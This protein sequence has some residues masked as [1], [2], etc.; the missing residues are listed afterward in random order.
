[1]AAE[2]T[3]TVVTG[4]GL[5]TEMIGKRSAIVSF[6]GVGLATSVSKDGL[7]SDSG[8]GWMCGRMGWDSGVSVCGRLGSDAGV[9][10]PLGCD[11]GSGPLGCDSGVGDPLDCDSDVGGRLRCDSEVVDGRFGGNSGGGCLGSDSGVGSCLSPDSGSVRSGSKFGGA[12]RC[13]RRLP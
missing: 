13:E 8:G 2:I 7:D 9:G 5:A 6:A 10:V 3:V 4:G 1:M 12:D 11:S